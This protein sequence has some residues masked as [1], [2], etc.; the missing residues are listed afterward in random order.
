MDCRALQNNDPAWLPWT[1]PAISTSLECQ[2]LPPNLFDIEVL[3]DQNNQIQQ[4]E[5]SAQGTTIHNLEPG[6]YT[7]N[8]IKV[9]SP[10]GIGDQSPNLE[11][12]AAAQQ[13]C[14]DAGFPD[15]GA[16]YND[17]ARILYQ[18]ICIEYEDEQGNDCS[19]VTLAAGEEKTCIVKNYIREVD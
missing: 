1:D 11:V 10:G 18:S 16:L 3:D 2:G 12:N 13:A 7:V 6:T 9:P 19:T 4:F 15:G 17:R 8:E 14:I 5:G